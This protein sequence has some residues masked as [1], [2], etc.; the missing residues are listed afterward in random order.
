MT[1]NT[2]AHVVAGEDSS[3]IHAYE[4]ALG[5]SSSEH[6]EKEYKSQGVVAT[7]PSKTAANF[8]Y[9]EETGNLVFSAY[10]YPDGNLSTV[11]EQDKKWEERGNTALVYDS[12]Y[13]RHWDTWTGN[14]G[15]QLF[16]VKLSKSADGKWLTQDDFKSPLQGTKHV[17][18]ISAPSML[19]SF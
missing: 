10:V 6:E 13:E 3:E 7:I 5:P 8:R 15:P 16:S 9:N 17:R 12:T 4:V 19:N 11:A 1:P 2:F 14:K 18:P